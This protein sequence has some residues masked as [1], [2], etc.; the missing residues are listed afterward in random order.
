MFPSFPARFLDNERIKG[1]AVFRA[2]IKPSSR[3]RYSS[4][5]IPCNSL[6]PLSLPVEYRDPSIAG[7]TTSF[8]SPLKAR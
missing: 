7:G 4:T 1:R 3:S 8:H 6:V 2:A 5:V